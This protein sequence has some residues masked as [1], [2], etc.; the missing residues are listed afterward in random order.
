MFANA[1]GAANGNWVLALTDDGAGDVGSLTN[2][3]IKFD[4]I[5]GVQTTPATWSPVAGLFSDAIGTPYTGTP[6]DT[7]WTRPTPSGVYNYN[8][9]V[10]SLNPPPAAPATPM[11][12]GNGNNMVF[13]N[14]TNNNSLTYN[15]TGISTNTF[16]SG[17]VTA[18][19]FYK[20]APIAGNPGL[21]NAGNGWILSG[22]AS[23]TVTA[24]ALNPVLTGLSI[25]IPAGATYGIGLEL[26]GA[27]FPA[28]TNGTG[29]IATYTNN[30]CTITVD[31]NVGWGGPVAPGPPA[32]NPRNFNGTVYLSAANFPACTSPAR[33]VTVTVNQPI[34]ITTQP[35]N[36]VICTD[37]VAVFTVSAT[38]TS[39]SYQW[40]VSTD[41][42]NT[43]N[44]INN[45]GV[46]SG[47]TTNTLT[48]TAP[49]VSMNGYQYR[50]AI[51][52]AIPC[53]T[54]FS[55][56]RLLTVNP[57]P[58]VVISA[59][60][61]YNL[62]PNIRTTITS[63]SSP[64]AAIYTWLRNDVVVTGAN[65]ST[66]LVNVDGLGRYRLRVTDVNGC[67]NTSN[68]ITIADSTSGRVFVSPNPTSGQFVVRYN[69]MHNNVLPRAI[70]VYD[71]KGQRVLVKNYTLGLP[72][73]PMAIDLSNQATGIYWLEVLDANNERL[74]VGRVDVIR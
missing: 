20:A 25:P 1:G 29:T 53:P 41:N 74:A 65:A 24:G 61:Y 36:A 56:A 40:Q 54:V 23:S 55:T 69:P 26:S 51:A 47:A 62:L 11:A 42:G 71:A 16:G 21:I 7:V 50:C 31:G 39:P 66:L 15:L 57:L 3:S 34:A 35:V 17:A 33:V 5:V 27:T 18:R 70:V 60:P 48:I 68:Q 14:V 6:R 45:G 38:G 44:L 4:Y 58:T 49:P 10:Q 43:W 19:V 46:Y 28:Y 73:A 72:F 67:V 8:V 52:G 2:W 22:T 64:A 63:T 12:G 32:N 13:F 9:T 30:G 59:S 37:K